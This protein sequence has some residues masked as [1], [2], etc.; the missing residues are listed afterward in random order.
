MPIDDQLPNE[1]ADEAGQGEGEG[2]HSGPVG[3]PTVNGMILAHATPAYTEDV[4]HPAGD[5]VTE[6]PV[7]DLFNGVINVLGDGLE[8]AIIG[9]GKMGHLLADMPEK[10]VS[11]VKAN[12]TALGSNLLRLTGRGR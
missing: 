6:V 7:E 10:I 2:Y 9:A 5:H 11:G 1:M 8:L 4:W 12:A 3:A